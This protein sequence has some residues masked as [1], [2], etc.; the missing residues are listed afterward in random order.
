MGSHGRLPGVM[1][2]TVSKTLCRRFD[3]CRGHQSIR[4][5][6]KPAHGRLDVAA[7]PDPDLGDHRL[8][9]SLAFGQRP[10]PQGPRDVLDERAP[11][12]P[13]RSADSPNISSASSERRASSEVISV[14]SSSMRRVQTSSRSLPSSKAWK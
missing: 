6:K 9:H 11:R 1:P 10:I 3:S 4:W 2:A 13:G 12:A 5:S 7:I 14:E 8:H